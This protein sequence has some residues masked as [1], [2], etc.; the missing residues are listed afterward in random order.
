MLIFVK[1]EEVVKLLDTLF[2]NLDINFPFN[3]PNIGNLFDN[4][5]TPIDNTI[6]NNFQNLVSHTYKKSATTRY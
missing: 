5:F 4:F 6:S 2:D 1:E 3:P